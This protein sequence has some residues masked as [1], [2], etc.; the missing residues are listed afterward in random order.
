MRSKAR[1]PVLRASASRDDILS[2]SES[3]A[4]RLSRVRALAS[5][6]DHA[7]VVGLLAGVARSEVV[8]EPELGYHLAYAWRRTGHSVQALELCEALEIPVRRSAVAWLVRRR[9]NLEA[10]L[11]FDRGEI[12]AAA[13]LWNAVIEHASEAG[14][15]ALLSAAHNNLGVIY[16]LQDRMDAALASYNRALLAARRLGDRRGVAQA[17]QNLA[18]LLREMERLR[19][20]DAHF[21]RAL[22]EADVAG[23][24]DVRGRVEE[25]RA[26]LLLDLDDVR[27]A[28]ATA[29]RALHGFMEIH[30]V[31]G[32]GEALRVLGIIALRR[33]AFDRARERLQRAAE[34][35]AKAHNA[36]L[37]AETLEALALLA[38]AEGSDQQAR[39]CEQEAAARFRVMNAEPWGRRIRARTA[40]LA[41]LVQQ[42]PPD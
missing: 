12:G 37:E 36:L 9:L 5:A 39:S 4:T 2:D 32:E 21:V 13:A 7:G 30:D 22:R 31:S 1:S 42:D 34:L 25:E 16:T 38:D 35:A 19:D 23:S 18:I 41:A 14:D 40:T 27:L 3:D 6:G 24:R 20:A 29:E 28:E 15:Q 8:A 33:R 10:M 17:H 26:L 11:R